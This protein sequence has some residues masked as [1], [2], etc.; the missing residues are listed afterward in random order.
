MRDMANIVERMARA[1]ALIK[2]ARALTAPDRPLIV[3]IWHFRRSVLLLQEADALLDEACV[4]SGMKPIEPPPT[5]W[6]APRRRTLIV[7]QW[8]CGT[9][10]AL[11]AIFALEA[12]SW[13][14]FAFSALCV[15]VCTHWIIPRR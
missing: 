4:L 12:G 1:E 11:S 10:N 5:P 6:Y 7:M 15:V 14:T 8:V 9:A 13:M 3:R 2:Q